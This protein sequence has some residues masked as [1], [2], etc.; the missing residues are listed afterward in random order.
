[1]SFFEKIFYVKHCGKGGLSKTIGF[2]GGGQ[3]HN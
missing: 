2:L 1:M 3:I